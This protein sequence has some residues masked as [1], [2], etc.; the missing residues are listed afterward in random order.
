MPVYR[1]LPK[2]GFTPPA[3]AEYAVVNLKALGS[4]PAGSVVEPDGLA[5]AGLIKKSDRERVKILGE[6]SVGH[7]LI[8]KVHAISAAARSKI[9]GQGGRVELLTGTGAD[10]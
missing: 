10:Q 1:R 4:F 9:E 2:R 8:L 7:A 6:G 3:R 5:A